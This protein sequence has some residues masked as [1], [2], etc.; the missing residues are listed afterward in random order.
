VTEFDVCGVKKENFLIYFSVK[1]TIS[2]AKMKKKLKI[3]CKLYSE[4]I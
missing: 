2:L 3:I 4:F 1:P